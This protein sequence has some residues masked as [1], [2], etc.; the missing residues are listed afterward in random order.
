MIEGPNTNTV[1][2]TESMSNVMPSEKPQETVIRQHSPPVSDSPGNKV[3]P[4]TPPLLKYSTSTDRRMSAQLEKEFEIRVSTADIYTEPSTSRLASE[5]KMPDP[6]EPARI[7]LSMRYSFN[8]EKLAVVVHRAKNLPM[9]DPYNLPD[10]FVKLYILPGRTRESRRRTQ[11][12]RENCNPVFEA[13]F[14][15]EMTLEETKRSELEVSVCS[16]K[17]LM[18]DPNTIL[19]VVSKNVVS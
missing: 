14:E 6:N 10:P 5:S 9:S 15:Y 18:T 16:Q 7:E 1:I 12:I 17:D 4:K 3:P 11:V 2:M 19:G 13:T 8:R